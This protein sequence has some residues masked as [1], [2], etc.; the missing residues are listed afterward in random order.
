[1][2][3][4]R[5]LAIAVLLGGAIAALTLWRAQPS[6]DPTSSE[7]K[8]PSVANDQQQPY[9]TVRLASAPPPAT[10]AH[11]QA[12]RTLAD[13]LDLPSQFEQ[14][15]RLHA[16]VLESDPEALEAL[17]DEAALLASSTDRAGALQILLL[18]YIELKPEQAIARAKQLSN[19]GDQQ[20]VISLYLSWLRH[21]QPGALRYLSAQPKR[22]RTQVTGLLRVMNRRYNDE[23]KEAYQALRGLNTNQSSDADRL[24]Q[25]AS[26]DPAGAWSAALAQSNLRERQQAMQK[27]LRVWARNDPQAALT[28]LETLPSFQRIRLQS[29]AVGR[30]L[31]QDADAAINWI[32]AQA[33][34]PGTAQ[35]YT[36]AVNHIAQTD[37]PRA[38]QMATTLPAAQ[39]QRLIDQTL[40]RLASENPERVIAEL[41]SAGIDLENS[42]AYAQILSQASLYSIEESMQ[43]ASQLEPQRRQSVEQQ[44][45]RLWSEEDPAAA[46]Q[47]LVNTA[48]PSRR[49]RSIRQVLRPWANEDP[50]AAASWIASAPEAQRDQMQQILVQTVSQVDPDA[51][52]L[53]LADIQSPQVHD[54]AAA[55]VMTQFIM[56]P[57]AADA[58]LQ[59]MRTSTGREQGK[60]LMYQ[61]LKQVNS[62]DAQR[63]KPATPPDTES[64]GVTNSSGVTL[65]GVIA[66]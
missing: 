7:R 48:D 11:D 10:K 46:A 62:P 42:E 25:Q 36:M 17:I 39:G 65:S 64:T 18:R 6:A 8:S 41:N 23:F 66:N 50:A 51:A 20:L 55:A 12:A 15:A 35:L 37:I 57:P 14:T 34:G 53:Y 38:L 56:D 29:S 28:A 13:L 16:L 58:I 4:L 31:R 43:R 61:V 2:R 24:E 49:Q 63:Y 59:S 45:Y 26:E 54:Q 22:L 9:T 19:L 3:V 33:P 47:H 52:L 21:D 1:M 5:Y 44:L 60:A 32:A 27:V 30:W 40:T